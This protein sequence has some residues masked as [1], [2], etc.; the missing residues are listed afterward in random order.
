MK[1]EAHHVPGATE[2]SYPLPLARIEP[3][4]CAAILSSPPPSAAGLKK[5]LQR[6]RE[7]FARAEA[8][9]IHARPAQGAVQFGEPFRVGGGV[10]LPHGGA[11]RIDFEQLP[12]FGVFEREQARIG[13][14][15]LTR[16]VQV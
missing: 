5:S 1:A 3:C 8:Q 13:Q 2:E 6:L 16:I 10:A 4:G 11:A 12:R 15:A 7:G 14:L 9:R